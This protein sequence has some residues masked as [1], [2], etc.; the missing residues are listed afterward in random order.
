MRGL[1]LSLAA[2]LISAAPAQ[3]AWQYYA[4]PSDNFASQFPDAPR[5]ENGR[6]SMNRAMG[7]PS[8]P[9][10][11]PPRSITSSIA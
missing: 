4:C 3:A 11:T 10:S 9:I 7:W 2:M 6:F 5:L 1:A 8:P